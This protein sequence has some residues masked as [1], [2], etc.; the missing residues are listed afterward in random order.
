MFPARL[1]FVSGLAS[2]DS[3]DVA[4]RGKAAAT[5]GLFTLVTL[6]FYSC[7]QPLSHPRLARLT[8]PLDNGSQCS[9]LFLLYMRAVDVGFFC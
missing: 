1:G 6:E 2:P 4:R 7:F 5:E 3:E 8:A 9:L